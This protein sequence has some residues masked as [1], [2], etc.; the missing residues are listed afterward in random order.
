MYR[1]VLVCR[2][3]H[4]ATDL[5]PH[6]QVTDVHVL[7]PPRNRVEPPRVAMQLRAA[8]Q[9]WIRPIVSCRSWRP[10]TPRPVPFDPTIQR[11]ASVE[12]LPSL[13]A[14]RIRRPPVSS[15]ERG[16]DRLPRGCPECLT[17][18]GHG[19][20]RSATAL[21]PVP[22]V[23]TRWSARPGSTGIVRLVAPTPIGNLNLV[24]PHRDWVGEP[25]CR[26]AG[27]GVGAPRP[28]VRQ[29]GPWQ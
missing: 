20:R 8:P 27:C 17:D 4:R 3:V 23:I 2:P 14:S 10:R 28:Q 6:A 7:S 16:D 11:H 9:A 19:T 26:P 5:Y 1:D 22:A 29:S 24:W 21:G 18:E 12:T 13:A 15:L 25:C